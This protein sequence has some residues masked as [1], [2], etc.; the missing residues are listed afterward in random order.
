[1]P[2]YEHIFLGR[3]DITAQQFE[4]LIET[5]QAI[6][7]DNGGSIEKMENWGPKVLTYK[8]KKNRKAHFALMNIDAPHE[9]VA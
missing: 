3:Q 5:Y 6:I 9:A 2:L 8:I 7:K 1:M 4:A